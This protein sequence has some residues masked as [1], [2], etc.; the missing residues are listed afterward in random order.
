[1]QTYD[2][3][4]WINNAGSHKIR[5]GDMAFFLF[6]LLLYPVILLLY[7]YAGVKDGYNVRDS[8]V[9]GWRRLLAA[10]SKLWESL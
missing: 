10:H 4:V 3:Y 2:T 6:A 5:E 7:L 9:I 8:W 1:M